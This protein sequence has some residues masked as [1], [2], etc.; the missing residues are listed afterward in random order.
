MIPVAVGLDLSLTRSGIALVAEGA[1]AGYSFGRKGSLRETLEDRSAR[2]DELVGSIRAL[3]TAQDGLPKIA[4][5]EAPANSAIG[6]SSHDRSGLW[7]QVYKMLRSL[8]IPVQSVITQHLKMYATGTGT[9]VAKED[10]LLAMVR[11][12][13]LATISN[14]DEADALTLALIGARLIGE[15]VDGQLA[16]V[17]TRAL[18]KIAL[19]PGVSVAPDF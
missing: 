2:L 4:M 19:P 18:D 1:M 6:G 11:R 17:Y 5:I 8:G 13:P 16:K 9:K 7:W 14:N 15:P 10:V 3:L 12:H